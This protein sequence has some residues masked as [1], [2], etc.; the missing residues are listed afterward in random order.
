MGVLVEHEISN[1]M[2]ERKGREKRMSSPVSESGAPCISLSL[3]LVAIRVQILDADA[4]RFEMGTAGARES[5]GEI[6]TM[7]SYESGR[8]SLLVIR[9]V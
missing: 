4:L 1:V 9:I 7:K 2:G 8:E 3:S 6:H 5:C